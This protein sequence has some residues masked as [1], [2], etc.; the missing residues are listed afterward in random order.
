MWNFTTLRDASEP[1]PPPAFEAGKGWSIPLAQIHPAYIARP[2]LSDPGALTSCLDAVSQQAV[3]HACWKQAGQSRKT[4][5]SRV[6][7]S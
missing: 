2:G 7:R 5:T 1:P 4:F 6:A 3:L